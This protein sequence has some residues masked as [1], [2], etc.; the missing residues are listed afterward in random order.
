MAPFCSMLVACKLE[1]GI[2]LVE[3]TP[4]Q[5][6]YL[7]NSATQEISCEFGY[8]SATCRS[9]RARFLSPIDGHP[10]RATS[11]GGISRPSA[12]ALGSQSA[13]Y[14][15]TARSSDV[16]AIEHRQAHRLLLAGF[17]FRFCPQ[18]HDTIE[19]GQL[20]CKSIR[21]PDEEYEQCSVERRHSIHTK[22]LRDPRDRGL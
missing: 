16:Q 14:S 7:A 3:Q 18:D 19:C 11:V 17:C 13:L 12:F 8:L 1:N 9:A 2:A 21:I 5:Q 22:L 4:A 6:K 20:S 10:Q 15:R